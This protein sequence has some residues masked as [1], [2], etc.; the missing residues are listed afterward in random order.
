MMHRS[1]ASRSGFAWLELLLALAAVVLLMQMWPAFGSQVLWVLDVR[2]WP[3]SVKI[4]ANL[5]FI[6]VL[7]G[8]RIGPELLNQWRERRLRIASERAK[9]AKAL[10]LKNQRET[11][12]RMKEAQSRRIY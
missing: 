11:L 5:L 4:I 10:E 8:I 7:V 3:S 9:A 2:N 6:L 12:E 1:R